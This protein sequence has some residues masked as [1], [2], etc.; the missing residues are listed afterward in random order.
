M[1]SLVHGPGNYE[2]TA[3]EPPARPT[4]AWECIASHA[5]SM[6]VPQL[7]RVAMLTLSVVSGWRL[8]DIGKLFDLHKGHVCREV[9]RARSEMAQILSEAGIELASETPDIPF[10]GPSKIH[11]LRLS[12]HEASALS[13]AASLAGVSKSEQIR[14]WMHV[15]GLNRALGGDDAVSAA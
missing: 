10:G 13:M 6:P 2:G 14:R 7:R 8:E 12:E 11:F 5:Q 9:E 4:S 1:P 3:A 15:G